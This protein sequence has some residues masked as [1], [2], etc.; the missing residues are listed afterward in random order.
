MNS[1]DDTHDDLSGADAPADASSVAA[2][3]L[4]EGDTGSAPEIVR[5]VLVQLLA[6][7]SID[8]RRHPN[9]WP[10]L[11]ANVEAVRMHLANLFL[12]LEL[13]PQL[14]V[15]FTRQA[16]SAEIDIPQLL[17]RRNLTLLESA[18]L[19]HLR[20]ELG[21]AQ[22]RGERAVVSIPDL[23]VHLAVYERLDSGDRAGFGKRIKAAIERMR[24]HSILQKIR[25]SEDRCEI[26]PT[27]KLL[28]SLEQVEGLR[29]VYRRLLESPN[30]T[31]V[32]DES[33][34]TA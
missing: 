31:S 10:A 12:N 17:R 20:S 27:L 34:P 6:G 33:S 11:L 13:D 23:E 18:L 21:Q 7:P 5:R 19:L 8:K 26:A 25:G 32:V 14:E 3:P 9:L 30:A 28:F 24:D 15:A 22:A 29:D 1:P 2:M 4:F 16:D